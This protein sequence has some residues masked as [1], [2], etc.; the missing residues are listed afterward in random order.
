MLDVLYHLLVLIAWCAAMA[1]LLLLPVLLVR[2]LRRTR[3]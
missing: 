3:R 1:G 2:A